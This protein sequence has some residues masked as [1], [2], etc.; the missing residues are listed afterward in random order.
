MVVIIIGDLN[1]VNTTVKR[2]G[3][4]TT[5]DSC[6]ENNLGNLSFDYYRDEIMI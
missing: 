2:I 3:H 6:L 5:E 4:S 1:S